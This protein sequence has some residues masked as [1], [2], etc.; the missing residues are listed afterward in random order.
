MKNSL[1][2]FLPAALIVG[3][4]CA[5]STSRTVETRPSRPAWGITAADIERS[6]SVPVEELLAARVPGVA[7]GR[8][9]DGRLTLVI[10]GP[11][12][13]SGA[14]EPLFVVNGIALGNPGNFLAVNRNDIESI[15]V[16][17]DA[18]STALYGIQGAGGVILVKTKGF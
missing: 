1:K 13:V 18:A 14:Q 9:S 16:L 11:S 6:P 10:R 17:K 7:L 5:Q 4:G 2:I 12:T 3:A 8:A 15:Q